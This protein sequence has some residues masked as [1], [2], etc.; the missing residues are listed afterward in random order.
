MLHAAS[1]SYEPATILNMWIRTIYQSP[2]ISE[3]QDLLI[4]PIY[5]INKWIKQLEK[6][7]RTL[8]LLE[9]EIQHGIHKRFK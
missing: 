2:E 4:I 6:Q 9:L 5:H 3:S 7:E 1:A 8:D